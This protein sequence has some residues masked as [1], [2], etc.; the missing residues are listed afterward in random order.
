M[1]H[2]ELTNDPHERLVEVLLEQEFAA[3][4]VAAP[5]ALP[6]RRSSRWLAAALVVLGVG[7]VLGTMTLRRGGEPALVPM[8]DPMQDP[9]PAPNALSQPPGFVQ[10]TDSE[11]AKALL[12]TVNRIVML[13]PPYPGVAFL[14]AKPVVLDLQRAREFAASLPLVGAPAA[15]TNADRLWTVSL[16]FQLADGRKLAGLLQLDDPALFLI[17]GLAPVG[18]PPGPLLETGR[19]IYAE[20]LT[21]VRIAQGFAYTFEELA[22]VP[23]TATAIQCPPLPPGEV[24]RHLGRFTKLQRVDQVIATTLSTST[25]ISIDIRSPARL[26]EFAVLPNLQHLG[27]SGASFTDLDAQDITRLPSLTSLSFRG[28]LG[29]LHEPSM[30]LLVRKLDAIELLATKQGPE[31]MR[32]VIAA[33]RIRKVALFGVQLPP[34][35]FAALAAM[36]TL[37]DL[38]L[39]G[40]W[41]TDA[42]LAQ[43]V[44]AHTR[45]ER[46]RL[47]STEVTPAGLRSLTT[48]P[49]LQELDLRREMVNAADL[50]A[51]AKALPN[52]K[53]R[54]PGEPW[55]TPPSGTRR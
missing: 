25:P 36:P 6:V 9:K 16:V 40:I 17:P 35:D 54:R 42:H 10:V 22:Q 30:R 21:N 3:Q 5:S 15:N 19:A 8:Q 31:L 20:L 50:E 27:M 34:E 29:E 48:L 2:G 7:A 24:T 47:Q 4:R 43:L 49:K 13:A 39:T 14:D 12:A 41:W 23:A 52:C 33:G 28:G 44:Q 37:R 55:D 18:L 11:Q 46:L 1:N 51:I 38:D 45:L 26:A 53:I 32:A